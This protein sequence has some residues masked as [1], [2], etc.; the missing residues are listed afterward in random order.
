M[1]EEAAPPDEGDEKNAAN[2]PSPDQALTDTQL[3]R[4]T[5]E[6]L[7]SRVDLSAKALGGLGTSA[8][9]A[10]GIAR[11]GDLFP[12]PDTTRSWIAFGFA[13]AGFSVLALGLLIFTY[14]L[15]SVNEPIFMRT[16][17]EA[18]RDMN[19]IDE[20]EQDQVER[21]YQ[22]TA[23]ANHAPTLRA[24]EARA[25][26]LY[27]IAGRTADAERRKELR[28]SADRITAEIKL[29]LARAALRILRRRTSNAVRGHGSVALYV[30]VAAG[31]LGFAL[32]T[33]YVS[34]ERSEQVKIAKACADARTAG[35]DATLPEICGPAGK[36]EAAAANSPAQEQAD[37]IV[38]LAEARQRCLA[39]IKEGSTDTASCDAIDQAMRT[40][41]AS[42]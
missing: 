26:R 4:A 31:I 14:R 42:D 15:W 13:I 39:L 23:D 37:A 40:L 24:Y 3:Y 12:V 22:R 9:T 5:A 38:A 25:E 6:K 30:F 28:E 36:E 27:R 8:L 20:K 16:D 41:I 7:R 2:S 17:D 1:S 32:G 19:D 29:T 33:D 11:I 18:M 35:A 34:S 21:V 10:V